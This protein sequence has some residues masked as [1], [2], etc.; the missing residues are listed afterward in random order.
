MYMVEFEGHLLLL[1]HTHPQNRCLVWAYLMHS[2][3]RTVQK[4]DMFRRVMQQR[5]DTVLRDQAKGWRGVLQPL[6]HGAVGAPSS[7]S[8]LI[9]KFHVFTT[10]KYIINW[11]YWFVSTPS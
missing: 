7:S 8:R 2:D 9:T 11:F 10:S 5:E 1:V 6:S 4:E 3:A